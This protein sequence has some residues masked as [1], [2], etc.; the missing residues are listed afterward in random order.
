MSV[1]IYNLLLEKSTYAFTWRKK[2]LILH[3]FYNKLFEIFLRLINKFEDQL[4]TAA[5]IMI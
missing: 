4:V 1:Y 5:N 2:V 3:S